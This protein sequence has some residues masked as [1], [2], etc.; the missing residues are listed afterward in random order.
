[1]ASRIFSKASLS[2]RPWE[3]HP[4]SAGHSATIQPSS[5]CSRVTWKIMLLPFCTTLTL[6]YTPRCVASSP[7]R[8]LPLPQHAQEV[9]AQ[10]QLH[11]G[12]VDPAVQ[13]GGGEGGELRGVFE[14]FQDIRDAVEVGADADALFAGLFDEVDEVVHEEGEGDLGQGAVRDEA[15]SLLPEFPRVAEVLLLGRLHLLLDLL[16]AL[17]VGPGGLGTDEGRVAVRHHDPA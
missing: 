12:A 6:Q 2:S 4:G 7:R 5:A 10:D 8:P 16:A 11:A 17:G 9:A 1:M 14:A 3:T 15:K 13:Q